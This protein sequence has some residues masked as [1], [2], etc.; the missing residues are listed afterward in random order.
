MRLTLFLRSGFPKKLPKASH[1]FSCN[2]PDSFLEIRISKKIPKASHYFSCN[3]PDSFLEIR[4]SKK[5]QNLKYQI[6]LL[7]MRLTTFLE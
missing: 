2:A 7:V 1:Y 6:A 5:K 4:I 3:V